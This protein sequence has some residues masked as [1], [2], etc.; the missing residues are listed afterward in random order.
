MRSCWALLMI[1]ASRLLRMRSMYV[2]RHNSLTVVFHG[3]LFGVHISWQ[4]G[5]NDTCM[6]LEQDDC[7]SVLMSHSLSSYFLSHLLSPPTSSVACSPLLLPP[8]HH[9]PSYFF[10][11]TLSPTL[12]ITILSPST[13]S[14]TSSPLLFL[15]T[16]HLPSYFLRRMLSPP[17]SS[18]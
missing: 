14:D 15:Q 16:H 5:G 13:S 1:L 17:T 7:F 3:V 12:S 2:Q 6:C 18:I 10:R 9:F 11:R 8:S 4:G